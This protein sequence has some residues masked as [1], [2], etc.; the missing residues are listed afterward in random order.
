MALNLKYG[1][2]ETNRHLRTAFDEDAANYDA[3]RPRYCKALFDTIIGSAG[4]SEGSSC[5]EIGP[6]TG[7]ATQPFLDLYL[8]NL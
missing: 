4:L 7:Q 1:T 8:A 5:M 2:D 3:V 6:G